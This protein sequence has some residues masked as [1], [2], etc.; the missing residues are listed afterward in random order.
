METLEKDGIEPKAEP[1]AASVRSPRKAVPAGALIIDLDEEDESAGQGVTQLEEASGQNME[2]EVA[3]NVP[4]LV[5][6]KRAG[7]GDDLQQPAQKKQKGLAP[8]RAPARK[9]LAYT[10]TLATR[11]DWKKRREGAEGQSGPSVEVE[12]RAPVAS[13][14]GSPSRTESAAVDT[15]LQRE[16]A[17]GAGQGLVSVQSGGLRV[18]RL[19]VTPPMRAGVNVSAFY[20]TLERVVTE[21]AD[22]SIAAIL[23]MLADRAAIVG[24][25]VWVKFEGSTLEVGDD[26]P[27]MTLDQF[28]KAIKLSGTGRGQ[29]SKEEIRAQV[30]NQKP[31][32]GRNSTSASSGQ[33]GYGLFAGFAVAKEITIMT[34]AEGSPTLTCH[35]KKEIWDSMDTSWQVPYDEGGSLFRNAPHGTH[36]VLHL[37]NDYHY[38]RERSEQLRAALCAVCSPFADIE[39]GLP[40]TLPPLFEGGKPKEKQQ[41]DKT[42]GEKFRSLKRQPI[43]VTFNMTKLFEEREARMANLEVALSTIDNNPGLV[44]LPL[45]SFLEKTAMVC[46]GTI[47]TVLGRPCIPN[48]A[49]LY[50]DMFQVVWQ[51]RGGIAGYT[52][53]NIRSKR[54]D[55]TLF[56]SEQLML[57]SSSLRYRFW[58]ER[59]WSDGEW[60]EKFLGI[61]AIVPS[62]KR[63]SPGGHFPG[64]ALPADAPQGQDRVGLPPLETLTKGVD[65]F[66]RRNVE[67]LLEYF[68]QFDS[69]VNF[70]ELDREEDGVKYFKKATIT[71]D[72]S[73]SEVRLNAILR[74]SG[75]D[76]N[77]V[78]LRALREDAA[79][80]RSAQVSL[81]TCRGVRDE[82]DDISVEWL[83]KSQV[84]KKKA[85]ETYR[86]TLPSEATCE[87]DSKPAGPKGNVRLRLGLKSA[88]PER[89]HLPAN[90]T[91]TVLCN[92]KI[93]DHVTFENETES[94]HAQVPARAGPAQFTLQINGW[95]IKTNPRCEKAR[96][97]VPPGPAEKPVL[98]VEAEKRVRSG[99]PI[100]LKVSFKDD[101]GEDQ[102]KLPRGVEVTAV[103]KGKKS[104][105]GGEDPPEVEVGGVKIDQKDRR[106]AVVTGTLKGPAQTV[107]LLV[108]I[109]WKGEKE[110]GKERVKV[111]LELT[112]G[113]PTGLT[114]LAPEDLVVENG[115]E[116]GG[117]VFGLSDGFNQ[118]EDAAEV[119]LTSDD[120][121][122]EGQA[123][124]KVRR[125]GS[126]RVS[127]LEGR[128]EETGEGIRECKATAV[129]KEKGKNGQELSVDFVLRVLPGKVPK[130]L[131][132]EIPEEG[133]K[134]SRV[135]SG[136]RVFA[137]GDLKAFVLGETGERVPMKT[138]DAFSVRW[139][140]LGRR[141]ASSG[142]NPPPPV[143]AA[144]FSNDDAIQAVFPEVMAPAAIGQY[145]LLLEVDDKLSE[146]PLQMCET[147]APHMA[148][149]AGP[150]AKIITHGG[151]KKNQQFD[152]TRCMLINSVTISVVDAAGNKC[153][154]LESE[155]PLRLTLTPGAKNP[156][157][158]PPTLELLPRDPSSKDSGANPRDLNDLRMTPFE[159]R[160]NLHNK[161]KLNQD[162]STGFFDWRVEADRLEAFSSPIYYIND[163][164][165]S[166]AAE[167]ERALQAKV[168]AV[169][170]RA[171]EIEHELQEVRKEDGERVARI[172]MLRAHLRER[173]VEVESAEQAFTQYGQRFQAHFSPLLPADVPLTPDN[174]DAVRF[175][176]DE[177]IAEEQSALQGPQLGDDV[178]N[179]P[180]TSL[181]RRV[182]ALKRHLGPYGVVGVLGDLAQADEPRV[183]RALASLV[184]GPQKLCWLVVRNQEAKD[185]CIKF[186]KGRNDRY[187]DIP[188]MRFDG[189][190][191]PH[192]PGPNPRFDGCIGYAANL[193]RLPS[194]I[195]PETKKDLEA[196]VRNACRDTLLFETGAAALE[197]KAFILGRGRTG[198]IPRMVSLDGCRLE[199]NGVEFEGGGEDVRMNYSLAQCHSEGL[200]TLSQARRALSEL[201]ELQ[202]RF[203]RALATQQAWNAP[204]G[205]AERI[206][207]EI[208]TLEHERVGPR[209]QVATL[210]EQ[211]KGLSEEQASIYVDLKRVQA[212]MQ[213]TPVNPPTPTKKTSATKRG[214]RRS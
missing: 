206:H 214:G 93:V 179:G 145:E 186:L 12:R 49:S 139:K 123:R 154:E 95:D 176:I 9:T 161:V 90:I 18:C 94:L 134:V 125:G 55:T 160:L 148:V 99:E 137:E 149:V 37:T 192:N 111:T 11:R 10:E 30:Q 155:I 25:N 19:D 132:F 51:H 110:D 120:V 14:E 104:T 140:H 165:L 208:S 57:M 118:L 115:G 32:M 103:V 122:F 117:L 106:T 50:P 6:N 185:A 38:T 24:S 22:N 146:P 47:N 121:S 171:A 75:R 180:Q 21:Y 156:D 8:A 212:S 96:V 188:F 48:Y 45:T 33:Y 129:Y 82:V 34:K 107:T 195:P 74:S 138:P 189:F 58:T 163:S 131:G 36:I 200:E 193:V 159:D 77:M 167:E 142:Q 72:G 73:T 17:R 83:M 203:G 88:H 114:V 13:S 201:R 1:F 66:T 124:R 81:L 100:T 102:A 196:V 63:A 69:S 76:G 23:R 133:G 42:L 62:R 199:S 87:V 79:G 61:G 71:M 157:A 68:A 64:G 116:L 182:R 20:P 202:E 3:Q 4:T 105:R 60:N 89:I 92:G 43:V 184:F 70:D 80:E 29:R 151:P 40:S 170:E 144:R 183:C 152:A 85:A 194:D 26:G 173:E 5:P 211:L 177:R 162:G 210:S 27:G 172:T 198:G 46:I 135:S 91:A 44:R 39:K 190:A 112:P 41:L 59:D 187:G 16:V 15:P 174:L 164:E 109:K 207:T 141:G 181:V 113:R 209:A 35:L 191:R 130:T 205:E 86:K 119:T 56:S 136:G 169:S 65:E 153:E 178:S 147:V 53:K 97:Q 143:K 150:P 7:D 101:T 128:G 52:P 31:P 197:Y 84:V 98:R 78:S 108:D 175:R 158:K 166:A 204:G 126:V 168:R 54:I 213:K 127:C 2:T 67:E 28:K